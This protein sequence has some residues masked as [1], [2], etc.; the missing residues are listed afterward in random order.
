MIEPVEVEISDIV[1][2]S[3]AE[4]QLKYQ[5]QFVIIRNVEWEAADGETPYSESSAST[6]RNIKDEDGNVLGVN[7]SNYANFRRA[8]ASGQGRCARYPLHDR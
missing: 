7:N 8:S 3:D 1:G 4:T 2:H 6:T 5:G